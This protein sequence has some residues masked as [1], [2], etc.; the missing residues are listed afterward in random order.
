MP[1]FNTRQVQINN[2]FLE[3]RLVGLNIDLA[4]PRQ[5]EKAHNELE[6]G[7]SGADLAV[8]L[9]KLNKPAPIAL[10]EVTLSG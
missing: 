10:Q 9:P 8:L 3:V 1:S 6:V 2:H 7:D 5:A 4:G